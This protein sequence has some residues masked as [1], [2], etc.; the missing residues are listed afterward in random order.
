MSATVSI[1]WSGFVPGQIIPV[2]IQ[3]ENQSSVEVEKVKVSLRK[4]GADP[5]FRSREYRR[6]P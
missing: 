4:V 2:A 1:P 6:T 3:Y 5:K